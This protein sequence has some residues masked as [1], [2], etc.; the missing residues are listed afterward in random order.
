MSA[1]DTEV[2]KSGEFRAELRALGGQKEQ[3]IALPQDEM[4]KSKG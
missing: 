2:L 3:N 1:L 4:T